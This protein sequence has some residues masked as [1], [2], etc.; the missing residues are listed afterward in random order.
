LTTAFSR[1]VCLT[2]RA[3]CCCWQDCDDRGYINTPRD[4]DCAASPDGKGCYKRWQSNIG[5]ASKEWSEGGSPWMTE[6]S[7]RITAGAIWDKELPQQDTYEVSGG[8]YWYLL[9]VQYSYQN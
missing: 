7:I 4:A 1:A 6:P 2:S 8:N 9:S 3:V 5:A